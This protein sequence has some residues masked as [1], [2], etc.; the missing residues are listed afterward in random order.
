MGS[1]NMTC[2]YSGLHINYGDEI[3]VGFVKEQNYKS[4][5]NGANE[6]FKFVTTLMP[7]TYTDYGWFEYE[8]GEDVHKTAKQLK[9]QFKLTNTCI[10]SNSKLKDFVKDDDK[11]KTVFIH[12][13]FVDTLSS[14][15]IVSYDGIS[16]KDTLSNLIQKLTM[17]E[18]KTPE[19]TLS[20]M[21][22]TEDLRFYFGAVYEDIISLVK[23]SY[24]DID[25]LYRAIC[26]CNSLSSVEKVLYPSHYAGQEYTYDSEIEYLNSVLEFVEN[27]NQR[28]KED[29]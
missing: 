29:E 27:K 28:L 21:R 9:Q 4:L 6:C 19:N 17:L 23:T 15:N 24:E 25:E 16:Y 3:Y 22:I 18:L 13:H 20:Y 11:V 2:A 8:C 7:A 1:F 26:T 10:N 5:N 14:K 12:K